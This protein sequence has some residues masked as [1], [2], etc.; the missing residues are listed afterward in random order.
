MNSYFRYKCNIMAVFLMLL[1]C[2]NYLEEDS[3]DL[4]IPKRVDE[5]APM[6]YEE[7]YPSGFNDE[8]SWFK[9][10]TDDVEMGRLEIDSVSESFETKEWNDF[11]VLYGGEGKLA[12]TWKEN[13]RGRLTDNFWNKRYENILACN[14][15][16]NELPVMDYAKQD[17]G[18]YN[19]LAAQA[20]ALR[21]YH[22]WCLVNTYALPYSETNLGK[23]GVIIRTNSEIEIKA[24]PRSS[25]REVYQLI[26]GDIKKAEEYI[27]KSDIP[28]NKHLITEPA[29]YLLASR[30]ALFQENWDEVIRVGEIFMKDKSVVFDLNTVDTANFGNGYD[31][32]DGFCIFDGKV[33]DEIVFTFGSMNYEYDFLAQTLS[34]SHYGLGFRPSREGNASLL[35]SY[36]KGDLRKMAYF[37]K[38]IPR[39]KAEHVWEEDK[40]AVYNYQYPMKYGYVKKG[41]DERPNEKLFRE[42]WRSVEV[43]LNLAEAYVRKTNTIHAGAVDLLNVLRRGRIAREVYTDKTVADFSGSEELLHFIWSE[44]RRELCFEE[45]MR[46]WDLRREGMPQIEHKWYT[47]WNTYETYVLKQGS[48]NYVLA[49]PDTELKYNDACVDNFREMINVN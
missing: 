17:S 38:D 36:E 7:G 4:L 29:V 44:R 48:S 11:D 27:V 42:N 19:Y 16:I 34:G 43:I 8:V 14:L 22:Y 9:L 41:G 39:K 18:K 40:P 23:A 37:E 31:A 10:M 46:F 33:N 30:I 47:S 28:G 6:L 3:G 5:F 13:F 26:N 35:A 49:I 15:V 24:Y 21:A 32:R 20:Y 1:G 12:Y 25:I 45:A 2:D